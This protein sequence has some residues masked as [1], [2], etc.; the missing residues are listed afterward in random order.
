MKGAA[1]AEIVPGWFSP[2]GPDSDVVIS[3]RLRLARNLADYPFPSRASLQERR[4]IFEQTVAAVHRVEL[5]NGFTCVNF[6][7]IEKLE[8]QAL[9]EKRAVSVEMMAMDGDRGVVVDGGYRVS[10]MVN[11]EDHLRLQCL[12]SGYAPGSTWSMVDRIDDA[13]GGVLSF[14][15]DKRW[16]FLTSC[17][18]NAGTGLRISFLMH[19]PGLVLTKTI[20]QI[21]QGA[22]QMGISTRGFFGEHSVV[23]GNFFQLS[24]Q[25]SMGASENEFIE[26]T[27]NVIRNV[28]DCERTARQRILGE[29]HREIEDK[30]YR[31]WGVLLHARLL[32]MD[33]LLN[34][35]SAL[36]LGI[37]CGLFNK[38]GLEALNRLTMICLPAHLQ[39]LH[40]HPVAPEDIDVCRAEVVRNFLK[41]ETHC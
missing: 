11:E 9:G 27:Q 3:T 8:Q 35:G 15:Y 6:L 24:N 17:P 7:D 32:G 4:A 14:A 38:L 30:V 10:L 39:L 26:A 41:T 19:L 29:A 16:G 31:A 23:V 12:E 36:R 20:D 34:L 18:T 37:E 33:E 1:A 40:A 5:F 13:L 21:L 2:T 22:S 25:S 28:I